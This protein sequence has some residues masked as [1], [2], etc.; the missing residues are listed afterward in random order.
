MDL[1]VHMRR[2]SAGTMMTGCIHELRA[3]HLLRW[4]VDLLRCH[5]AVP[6]LPWVVCAE[7]HGV[8]IAYVVA[9]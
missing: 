1:R 3:C 2:T 6:T 7:G 5:A 4:L 8:Q 9:E